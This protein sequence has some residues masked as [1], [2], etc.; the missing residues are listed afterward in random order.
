MIE[1]VEKFRQLCPLDFKII[2]AMCKYGVSNLS[3]LATM[4][5]I[6][7]Q[8]VSYHVKKFDEL[9]LVRFRALIDEAKLG[10][11]NYVV[12]A[13]VPNGKENISSLVMTCFPLW[14]YLA[15][16]D[17]W[18]HGNFVRYVIPP[19]K[20][21]D[22]E[23]FLNELEKRQFIF[24]YTLVP[25]TSPNYPLLNLDFYAEKKGIPVFDWEKWIKDYD[26]LSEELNEPVNY[27]KGK[28]DLYDLI[29]LRCLEL[30]ARTSQR[31][32]V[33]EMA[34]ILK[35]KKYEKFI[36]LVSRRLKNIVTQKLI[37]GYRTYLFPYHGPTTLFITYYLVFS[38]SS[39]LKKFIAAL[40][41]LPYNTSYEKILKK[42]ELF[43]RIIIPAHEYPNLRRSL[44]DMALKGHLKDAHL[45]L[46]DLIHATWDNVEIY[47]MYKD[48]AWNFSYG[49]A[50][51][52]LESTLSKN[53]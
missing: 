37:R 12:L 39:S 48:E 24:G 52:M 18:R 8:T 2:K 20:E 5:G 17:G 1:Y 13:S 14:R 15:I 3:M 32:I 42:D 47:Q 27:E 7:Q 38:S 46:G 51:E 33:K 44:I 23:S 35:E 31:E 10:L 6:P 28:F 36:P 11:K 40:N 29:I 21:R 4:I 19:D 34:E 50:M 22:L 43:V 30:N 16:V 41:Y 53:P 49:I 9:D 25:T 26:L 45:L